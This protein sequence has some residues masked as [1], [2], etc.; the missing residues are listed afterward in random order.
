M[1]FTPMSR[2]E[3]IGTDSDSRLSSRGT[4]D[5]WIVVA[6]WLAFGTVRALLTLAMGLAPPEW[7]RI[8]PFYSLQSLA[9]IALTFAVRPVAAMASRQ[10]SRIAFF[11][12]HASAALVA[13]IVDAAVRRTLMAWVLTPAANP[14]LTTVVF[15][16]E[17]TVFSYM[18]AV[19]LSRFLDTRA[20]VLAHTRHEL[21]L[22]SRLTRARLEYLHAQLQPHFLFNALAAVSELVVE[23]PA[24]AVRIY[25]QLVSV[26][27]FASSNTE[28]EIRLTE[29]IEGLS[30]YLDVQRTRFSDWLN[31]S[32][33][34]EDAAKNL[35]VPSFM[36]QPLVENA[37][38]HGLRQ[39]SSHGSVHI[40]ARVQ[41][42]V[43]KLRVSDDGVG[44]V[45]GR[46]FHK[47][48]VGLTNT[49][50]RL[51]ALYGDAASLELRQQ[52]DGGAT[53]EI[54]LPA[55][56]ANSVNGT[57]APSSGDG[58]P[59]A[60]APAA[61]S[62]IE[63]RPILF[64]LLACAAAAVLR[65]QQSYAYLAIRGRL[66]EYGLKEMIRADFTAVALWG[67]IVPVALWLLR[68][69][70]MRREG[71]LWR[72]LVHTAA[73][74]G[75]SWFHATAWRFALMVLGD[76]TP[77][78]LIQ[79][80][81]ITTSLLYIVL[82]AYS[83]RRELERWLRER[84]VAALR[85]QADIEEEQLRAASVRVKPDVL[86]RTLD[87]LERHASTDPE[88]AEAAIASLG[89][90]LRLSL[91]GAYSDRTLPDNPLSFERE[92]IR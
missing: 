62:F 17:M 87:S 39:R 45:P 12:I 84:Q 63:R 77:G 64:L 91:A 51:R 50:E 23:S 82:I 6:A 32:L 13:G 33:E 83:Q 8:I 46:S 27:Q 53:A 25:K 58:L 88:Q 42:G 29:E 1:R 5:V 55:R 36:L 76:S 15:F 48:G 35:L 3:Q 54:V 74:I 26:L 75:L 49:R 59:F 7:V 89:S 78:E 90:E 61:E 30:P 19:F 80:S 16:A 24:K 60:A 14:F 21:T 52:A 34:I 66:G 11:A 44:L 67:T 40:S 72:A 28:R 41:S 20:A 47:A 22:R 18:V 81:T 9:W 69:I 73:A 31:I 57:G 4:G 85:L 37:I 68:R 2:N 86:A 70:P 10:Q 71:I 65:T 79:M 43:L 92:A 38:R 56:D